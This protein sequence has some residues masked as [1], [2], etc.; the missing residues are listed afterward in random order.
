[1]IK[2]FQALF[3]PETGSYI[4]IGITNFW[5]CN[6]YLI[7]RPCVSANLADRFPAIGHFYGKV[8]ADI[9]LIPDCKFLLKGFP[10]K[11][12]RLTGWYYLQF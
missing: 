8:M 3:D 7:S 12:P 11:P 5:M 1:M 6:S 2:H 10:T 9:F 4:Q